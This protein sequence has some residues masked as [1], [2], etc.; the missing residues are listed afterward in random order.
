MSPYKSPWHSLPPSR[1]SPLDRDSKAFHMRQTKQGYWIPAGL[2]SKI[3][4]R[5]VL[6][7]SEKLVHR[8]MNNGGVI[9]LLTKRP[10]FKS[11][12]ELLWYP[13]LRLAKHK[14]FTVYN[15]KDN[16]TPKLNVRSPKYLYKLERDAHVR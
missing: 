1:R 4:F 12:P 11:I 14:G 10:L 3:R 5:R 16:L 6:T 8:F 2:R 9:E 15:G 7:S 13:F